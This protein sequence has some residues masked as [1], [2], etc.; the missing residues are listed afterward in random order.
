MSVDREVKLH[1][2]PALRRFF[3]F[4]F[5]LFVSKVKEPVKEAEKERLVRW[6]G[7]FLDST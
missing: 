7:Q 4:F 6:E 2:D 3:F 1:E 5:S